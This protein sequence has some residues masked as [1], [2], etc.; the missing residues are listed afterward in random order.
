MS[1]IMIFAGTTEGRILCESCRDKD[2]ILDVYVAT[3]KGEELIPK[4]PNITVHRGR[5]D[6]D[7][8][9]A[10]YRR[11]SPDMVVDATHPYAEEISRNIRLAVDKDRYVRLLR[12]ESE[13][14][15]ALYAAD[16]NKAIDIVNRSRG[17]VLMT[18]GSKD[19]EKYV[20]ITDYKKRLYVRMLPE[21]ANLR[22][23]LALGIRLDHIID[24]EG[25]FTEEENVALIEEYNIKYLVTKES[26]AAGGFIEKY[27]ACKSTNTVMVVVERP[28]EKGYTTEQVIKM[29]EN[30][31]S[32]KQV[33]IIGIGM[34]NPRN[35]TVEAVEAIERCEAV[36]GAKRMVDA[37]DTKG[38]AVYNEYRAEKIKEF[39]DSHF[40]RRIAV[41]FSG[42]VCIYSGAGELAELLEDCEVTV[43]QG[44]SSAA[45]LASRMGIDYSQC[46]VISLHGREC[47][48]VSKVK[49]NK[50]IF[51][52]TG[53]NTAEI[54]RRLTDGGLGN[55]KLC[56]GER[57]SYSNEKISVGFA[58]EFISSAFD[59]VTTV[60]IEN[61]NY[62][63]ALEIGIDDDE[64][65]RGGVPMT[66]A[67]VRACVISAL[68]LKPSYTVYDIGAGTGS[69]TVEISGLAG[70]VY[71]IDCSREACGLIKANCEKFSR[72]NVEI[73]NDYAENAIDAL[74]KADCVFIGGTKGALKEILDKI[75]KK[76]DT[77]IVMTAV[78]VETAYMAL[79]YFRERGM[80]FSLKQ[81]TVARGRNT[82]ELTMLMSEN[83]V[84]VISGRMEK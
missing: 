45:Y 51:V 37:A 82:G 48:I 16:M 50:G 17:N 70:R 65:I 77:L 54:C 10:E 14:V 62:G 3:E 30:I 44:I 4:A 6:A 18:T 8:I 20:N 75:L 32:T 73:I 9:K 53:G 59:T 49:E 29:A 21:N 84:F 19:L 61:D 28:E 39:I 52:L 66:K 78:S 76:G 57:L 15:D 74:P 67:E 58:H 31:D 12:E 23:A 11:I 55:V 81:I 72:G 13:R 41:L 71:A 35:M 56:I 64:F 40:Y 34:G 79:D 26:G 1:R 36:I 46:P 63:K 42:D 47:D 33:Y 27:N 2:M 68:S 60:Y 7:G 80:S 24:E 83:P 69:V 5:L 25:P 38:K 22:R 43:I